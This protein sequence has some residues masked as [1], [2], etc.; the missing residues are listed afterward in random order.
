MQFE[1]DPRPGLTI[2]CDTQDGVLVV[3]AHGELDYTTAP[4][5]RSG[6]D[7]VWASPPGV[8]FVLDLDE[9]SFCDSVGLSELIAT[10]R[11]AQ[12]AGRPFSLSGV[13]GGVLR[14]LTI[15][16]LRNVFDIH[17]T[18]EDAVR[19]APAAPPLPEI[20]LSSEIVPPGGEPAAT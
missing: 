10:L 4:V 17:P 14:V 12:S 5:L 18:A 20:V 19:D 16:G 9:V 13:H 1:A 6:L 8:A 3:R 2:S 7:P 11:T 15:T